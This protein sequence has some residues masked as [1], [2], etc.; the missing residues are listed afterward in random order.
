MPIR[1]VTEV[2]DFQLPELRCYRTLSKGG[3]HYRAGLFVAEGEKVVPRL[4]ESS[5]EVVSLLA[6]NK[7]LERLEPHLTSRQEAIDV[8]L[9]DKPMM[10]ALTGRTC[11]QPVKA[12]G[13][14]PKNGTVEM[15]LAKHRS[16][17]SYV[18]IEGLSNADNVGAVVRNCVAFGV[19]GILVSKCAASPYLRRAVHTSMGTVFSAHVVDSCSLVASLE[20]L[21]MGGIHCLAAHPSVDGSTLAQI[22]LPPSVCL[23]LGS[24]GYGLSRETLE[25]C[26]QSAAIP[27][28][29]E[30]DSLNVAS[31]SA[32]FLYELQRRLGRM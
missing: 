32:V 15:L 21:K 24:E 8:F 20:S 9:V 31:S 22:E 26:D 1:S 17:G 25:C 10:E 11:Y 30:V 5:I 13:R 2:S 19:Q 7:W 16:P 6:S 12:V 14:V 28:A 27:M 18:A 4:L 3:E 29:F 23:V